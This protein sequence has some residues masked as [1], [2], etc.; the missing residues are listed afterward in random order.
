MFGQPQLHFSRIF[1]HCPVHHII[2]GLVSCSMLHVERYTCWGHMQVDQAV[3]IRR[4]YRENIGVVPGD[5]RVERGTQ[6]CLHFGDMQCQWESDNNGG[7]CSRR[8]QD[9][10][11]TANDCLRGSDGF[12]SNGLNDGRRMTGV[13]EAMASVLGGDRVLWICALCMVRVILHFCLI[14]V[15]SRQA[16]IIPDLVWYWWTQGVSQHNT[17]LTPDVCIGLCRGRGIEENRNRCG[18]S[19][20]QGARRGM[21]AFIVSISHWL[22][23]GNPAWKM[24]S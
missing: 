18:L 12:R 10:G 20:L 23:F 13:D 5:S 24:E 14:V 16:C 19:F 2:R 6:G 3:R 21:V 1:H 8:Q 7:I 9:G 4:C 17:F 15:H 11:W 22:S